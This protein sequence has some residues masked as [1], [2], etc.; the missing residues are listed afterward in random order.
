MER[1]WAG[2][3]FEEYVEKVY[4]VDRSAKT[5]TD[6]WD[7]ELYGRPVS[8][9]HTQKGQAVCLA[10]LFRQASNE[11]DFFMFV[12]FYETPTVSETDDIHIFYIP[13]KKWH[14]YFMDIEKFEDRFKNALKSVT[15]DK[16]DDEKW[17]QLRKE[18][19]KFWKENTNKIITVNGKRDHKDQKRWQCSINKTNFF[20]E[21][22]PK[23]EITEE[24]L[25]NYA[26]RN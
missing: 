18:C 9:K 26:K 14:T 17:T 7:G 20:K 6:I 8:I 22:I 2:F 21:I 13:A 16:K 10:D 4:G 1:Q 24:E 11:E 15:N 3:S 25:K 19:V 5:Y 23:Y 12:D